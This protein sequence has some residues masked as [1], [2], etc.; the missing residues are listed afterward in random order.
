ML[1]YS[2]P[3]AT[4][5]IATGTITPAVVTTTKGF[6]TAPTSATWYATRK[7][8]P[9]KARS[10]RMVLEHTPNIHILIEQMVWEAIS[11][12]LSKQQHGI[13]TTATPNAAQAN[14]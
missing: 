8:S 7:I 9:T 2:S 6:H 3:I 11:D 5:S 12:R 13:S 14:D 10:T 1:Y 4:L